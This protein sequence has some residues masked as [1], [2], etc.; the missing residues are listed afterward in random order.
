MSRWRQLLSRRRLYAELSEE[1]RQHLEEKVEAL[2]AS[3]LGRG[4]AERRAR[5]EFGNVALIEERSREVWRWP[6]LEAL[7]ADLRFGLRQFRKAPGFTAAVVA[8]LALGVGVNSGVFSLVHHV[9]IEPLPF[10]QPERLYAVWAGSEAMGTRRV[11]ASGPDFLDYFDQNRSFSGL[12]Q[13]IPHF[14]FTW[15][16]DGEPRLVNC[17]AVSPDFFSLL[18]IRPYLGRLYEPREYTYLENGSIIVSYGFWR[19]Q[20]AGDPHVLGRAIHFDGDTQT[21][22]GVLPPLPDLFPDTEVWPKLTLRPSWPYMKWRGNKFLR[23][24]GRLAPG[25]TRAMAEDDLTAILRRAPGEAPDVRV[26]LVPLKDDLVGGVHVYLR[27]VMAAVALVLLTACVN[28][29]ALLLARSVKRGDEMALRVSLG[30]GHGRLAQ[31]LMVEGFLLVAL[32]SVLGVVAAWAGLRLLGSVPGLELPR[33]AGVHLSAAALAA[34]GAV[35]V[36]A[37]LLF[38]WV[39]AQTLSGLDLAVALRRGRMLAGRSHRRAFSALVVAEIGCSVVLAVGAGLLLHSFWRVQHVDPGF[40]PDSMLSVYLRTNDYGPPGRAFWKD[41]LDGV[42]ALPAVSSA[43]LA[44][45]MPGKGAA[46]ATLVFDD[47]VNDPGQASAA[48]GCWISAGF[49]RTSGTLLLGGR[50]FDERDGADA[51]PVVI[52]NAEAARRYWPGRSPIGRWIGVN[53]TGPGRRGG[54]A[55]RRRQV[56]GV[57]A[58]IKQGA[59]DLPTEPAVYMPYLQDE[60]GHDLASMSVFVRSARDPRSLAGSVRARIHAVR[61]DQPVAE[62]RTMQDVMAQALAPR[63]YSLWLLEA[64]AALAI[65]LAALGLYGVAAYTAAQRTRE[66]GLRMALGAS[67]GSV[68]SEVLR[69]GLALTAAG[70]AAGAGLAV[71][72]SRAL[73]QLLFEVQP[74]DPSSF[75]SAVVL[76]GLVALGACL[77]PA[78]RASRVDPAHALRSD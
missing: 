21:I 17:T 32:A 41:V 18:G 66:F 42:A 59:L 51:P 22:V 76:L 28:V 65:L 48:Q 27:I 60:T 61:P 20:L 24:I 29:A 8:V 9:L 46:P 38:A 33:L 31:Q 19:H 72:A 70:A 73:S 35:A 62:L 11:A 1:I 26:R 64:F 14:T 34:T 16:G 54:E 53:Y 44:D 15:T 68:L 36:G 52:V 2:V 45:C 12:A 4:E 37:T 67:R 10:P 49:F 25:A 47:R 40:R 50:S 39:P 77:L 43:A 23:V 57:V 55:P 3:G 58:A 75:T 6:R 63:R 71:A 13:I 56:V 74:L 69:Q 78:W 30:A 5:R 7:G